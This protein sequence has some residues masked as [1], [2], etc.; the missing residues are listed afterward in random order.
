[1]NVFDGY[2]NN[3]D[4]KGDLAAALNTAKDT[5]LAH[6]KSTRPPGTA[7]ISGPQYAADLQGIAD[8]LRSG[9]FTWPD[10]HIDFN[11]G[12]FENDTVKAKFLEM[13]R[14]RALA[15]PTEPIRYNDELN[16]AAA[17]FAKILTQDG[18]FFRVIY[19]FM[20]DAVRPHFMAL[21]MQKMIDQHTLKPDSE[22]ARNA[23]GDDFRDRL[24]NALKNDER[25]QHNQ[26]QVVDSMLQGYDDYWNS[27]FGRGQARQLAQEAQA[28]FEKDPYLYLRTNQRGQDGFPWQQV[29]DDITQEMTDRGLRGPLVNYL[30]RSGTDVARNWWQTSGSW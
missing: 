1:M 20:A 13:A 17:G 10:G 19:G 4:G 18:K 15:T 8:Q 27:D 14:Y 12:S 16:A 2:W 6:A 9:I 11:K 23:A 22:K 28:T 21:L 30:Q 26:R 25:T 24:I 29:L 5:F 3:Q 7:P